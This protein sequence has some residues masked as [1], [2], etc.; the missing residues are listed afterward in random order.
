MLAAFT[1]GGGPCR[2]ILPYRSVGLLSLRS[3]SREAR[4]FLDAARVR[5]VVCSCPEM[6]REALPAGK[7]PLPGLH[8]ALAES[9]GFSPGG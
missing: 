3:S 4:E 8:D 1:Q 5:A 6:G 9:G 7:R 2:A